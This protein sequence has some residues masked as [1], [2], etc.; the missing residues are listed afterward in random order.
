MLWARE[1]LGHIIVRSK[2]QSKQTWQFNGLLIGQ[3][4][5]V[6]REQLPS[7]TKI[8]L[9]HPT[10]ELSYNFVYLLQNKKFMGPRKVCATI[11]PC[12]KNNK[13][14]Q[15]KYARRSAHVRVLTL[16]TSLGAYLYWSRF[17]TMDDFFTYNRSGRYGVAYKHWMHT[18]MQPYTQGKG[19]ICAVTEMFYKTDAAGEWCHTI[20]CHDLNKA[21]RVSPNFSAIF[22]IINTE[23][24]TN[25]DINMN[26]INTEVSKYKFT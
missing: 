5:Q 6:M 20:G 4:K 17:H 19:S 11:S 16:C 25:M 18:P 15:E 8:L 1:N 7:V 2:Q 9:Q 3:Y 12:S 22:Q 13:G 24:D 26:T 23:L 14:V 10:T 21:L